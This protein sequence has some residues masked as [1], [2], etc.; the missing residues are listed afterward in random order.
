MMYQRYSSY[1]GYPIQEKRTQRV[2]AEKTSKLRPSAIG[3]QAITL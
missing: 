1:D 2:P 3:M